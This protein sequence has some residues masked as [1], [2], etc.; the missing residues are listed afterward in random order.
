MKKF[1]I[2]AVGVLVLVAGAGVAHATGSDVVTVVLLGLLAGT[3]ALVA[4]DT[5]QKV[6]R[7]QRHLSRWQK[8]AEQRLGALENELLRR[9]AHIEAATRDDVLGTVKLMQEQYVGRLDRARNE[10]DEAAAALRAAVGN[11]RAE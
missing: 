9:G 10:L 5:G 3:A 1:A 6:R 8:V 11:T 7:Q 4:L 2:A